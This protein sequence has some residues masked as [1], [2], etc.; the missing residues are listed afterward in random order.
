MVTKT[1]P[2]NMNMRQALR[3]EIRERAV[4]PT[5]FVKQLK[6]RGMDGPLDRDY[7]VVDRN[8]W[9]LFA[10]GLLVLCMLLFFMYNKTAADARN[11]TQLMYIKMYP[12][13]TWDMDFFDSKR[14]VE[15]LP[16]TVDSLLTNWVQ[17]RFREDPT[18]VSKDYGFARWF[19]DPKTSAAFMD[20]AQGDALRKATQIADCR[21]CPLKEIEIRTISHFDSDTGT[22]G[23]IPGAFYRTNVFI[24]EKMLNDVGNLMSTKRKIVKV[25]WR[26][27]SKQEISAIVATKDGMD[28]VRA[29]P[30]GLQILGYELLVDPSDEKADDSSSK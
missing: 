1:V 15:F 20:P 7:L 6:A 3:D 17:R 30:I 28:W 5:S 10:F 23:Q 22:F 8:R 16:A 25:Q 11:N 13:G 2:V 18:T 12:D 14:A 21:N 4:T 27:M 26:L 19:M 24:R 29:N 9:M